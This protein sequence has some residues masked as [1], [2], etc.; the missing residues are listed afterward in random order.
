MQ[1]MNDN[2]VIFD[3][4]V[5]GTPNGVLKNMCLQMFPFPH[6]V[7]VGQFRLYIVFVGVTRL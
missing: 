3:L 7:V 6:M 5:V 1:L 4:F 2:N